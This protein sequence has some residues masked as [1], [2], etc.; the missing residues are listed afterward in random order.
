MQSLTKTQKLAR[1]AMLLAV[2]IVLSVPPLSSFRFG[3][4]EITLSIVPVALGGMMLGW[5]TGLALGGVFGIIS[6]IRAFTDPLGVIMI[7]QSVVLSAMGCILPRMAVGLLADGFHRLLARR[8]GL[9]R[10]WFY[11]VC[12]AACSLCNTILFLGFIGLVFDSAVT[13][14]TLAA[15]LTIV[16]SNGLVEVVVNAFFVSAIARVFINPP[17]LADETDK[18]TGNK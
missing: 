12:G 1:S 5:P 17:P 8:Q 16:G 18:T 6:F 7:G 4:F 2:T 11:A 10:L 13:G 14:V 9:R 3:L 15:I